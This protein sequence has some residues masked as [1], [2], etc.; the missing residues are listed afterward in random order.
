M[1]SEF[2]NLQLRH[3]FDVNAQQFL[4]R[5]FL[6]VSIFIFKVDRQGIRLNVSN[7]DKDDENESKPKII[8][9]N[10][11]SDPLI[12]MAGDEFD[13]TMTLMNTH[14]EKA[15][16][17][18]KKGIRFRLCVRHNVKPQGFVHRAFRPDGIEIKRIAAVD[19]RKNIAGFLSRILQLL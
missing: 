10:Y 2:V 13:L 18:I 7:P 11:V 19:R 12:V 4:R 17:N 1:R 9:S 3:L 14:K 5:I 8:V 16:K 6:A 15:V